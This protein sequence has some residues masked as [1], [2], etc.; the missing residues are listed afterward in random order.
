MKNA[1]SNG[2]EFVVTAYKPGPH[3]GSL[4]IG[5]G[6]GQ[7][8]V[9]GLQWQVQSVIEA[10]EGQPPQPY[11]PLGP[12]HIHWPWW[13]WVSIGL[14]VVGTGVLIWWR[15]R[16]YRAR[17]R[18]IEKIKAT[19]SVLSPYAQ[20][21]KDLRSLLRRYEG[22]AAFNDEIRPREYA[23]SLN[24]S[25]RQYLSRELLT[26]AA[27]WSDSAV[28]RDIQKRHRQLY[29]AV[30][31]EIHGLLRELKRAGRAETVNFTD[32]AQ[33]HEM[34]RRTAEKIERSKGIKR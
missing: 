7:V 20:L 8:R 2:A 11:G 9:S 1:R 3:S 22:K 26:P 21:H 23:K 6:A 28:L 4:L 17:R 33:L 12:Q 29:R 31:S 30:G 14:G 15:V 24:E 10:Q 16:R 27:E 5:S 19:A 32:C 34:S 13:V 25:F 18:L